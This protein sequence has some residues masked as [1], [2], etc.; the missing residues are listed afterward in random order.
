[1]SSPSSFRCSVC[2]CFCFLILS[3][4]LSLSVFLCVSV[5]HRLRSNTIRLLLLLLVLFAPPAGRNLPPTGR[6]PISISIIARELPASFGCGLRTVFDDVSASVTPNRSYLF[7]CLDLRRPSSDLAFYSFLFRS[8]SLYPPLFLSLPRHF[9]LSGAKAS[10][11]Q[12]APC[13]RTRFKAAA[14]T[15]EEHVAFPKRQKT[16]IFAQ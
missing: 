7:R 15:G 4:S 3:L 8:F 16:N 12:F 1:M 5:S 14:L 11:N 2:F 13:S 9:P 10:N 6:S